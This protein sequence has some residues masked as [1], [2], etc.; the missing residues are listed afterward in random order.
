MN[1]FLFFRYGNRMLIFFFLP[2]KRV[3]ILKTGYKY[4]QYCTPLSQSNC[5]YFFVL[6][7]KFKIHSIIS[8]KFQRSFNS[9]WLF[10]IFCLSHRFFIICL[11]SLIQKETSPL[12][13]MLHFM[14]FEFQI[15]NVLNSVENWQTFSKGQLLFPTNYTYCS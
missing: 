9:F 6:E 13:S 8:K 1:T 15:Y 3:Q 7:I 2:S 14:Y 12:T 11:K 10:H 4:S 5:R